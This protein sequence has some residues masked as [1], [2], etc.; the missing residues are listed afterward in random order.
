LVLFLLL[1]ETAMALLRRF[2]PLAGPAVLSLA[3][4]ALSALAAA[5][6]TAQR[7]GSCPDGYAALRAGEAETAAAAFEACLSAR[8][9]EWP[10][11]AE[12]RAR[13]GAAQL[14]AGDAD[15]ALLTYNQVFALVDGNG[16]DTDNPLLRR[17]RAAA[18]LQLDQGEA[19]LAD[20]ERVLSV[21]PDD[22]FAQLV[23]GSAYLD[24]DRPEEAV[25]A[26]DTALRVDP[27]YVSAW[28]GRSAAFVELGLS[29]Q[30]V[31]D[32]REAVSIAPDDAG[33]LNALCWALVKAERAADGLEICNA[34]VEADPDSGPIVHSRAAAL[35][36]LG[37]LDEAAAL[38]A[39]AHELAP[40]DPEI[41]ADYERVHGG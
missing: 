9:Y 1:T 3:V 6:A 33:A 31:S 7:S 11:E 18:Y 39:R 16:G 29:D 15:A 32:G 37:R 40:D 13:L 35:E 2:S 27:A 8:L 28:I 4:L 24:L 38:Y 14:A 36:Q 26:F 21:A 23:A 30:A 12:L 22:A 25:A 17:N 10:V 5:P 34:A 41:T 19:A 20:I